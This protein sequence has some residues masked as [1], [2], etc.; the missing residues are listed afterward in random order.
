[1]LIVFSF[2]TDISGKILIVSPQCLSQFDCEEIT[3]DKSAKY[4]G[5]H[6]HS[7]FKCTTH[8]HVL[9]I[10]ILLRQINYKVHKLS[11]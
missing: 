8:A 5:H 2:E 6:I 3:Y 1:M 11:Q 7:D 10:T 4:L 9:G